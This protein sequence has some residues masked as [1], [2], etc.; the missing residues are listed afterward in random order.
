[1]MDWGLKGDDRT[2]ASHRQ[3]SRAW[4]RRQDQ[5]AEL[6]HSPPLPP[7]L[8]ESWPHPWLALGDGEAGASSGPVLQGLL[9]SAFPLTVFSQH[10]A[11]AL[12]RVSRGQDGAKEQGAELAR[13]Q[14]KPS[15]LWR[16]LPPPPIPASVSSQPLPSWVGESQ[17]RCWAR[18]H[19]PPLSG[20]Q[21]Y[22]GAGGQVKGRWRAVSVS[23][24]CPRWFPWRS[25]TSQCRQGQS[26]P[27]GVCCKQR[28]C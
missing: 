17:A 9:G 14:R 28:R 19:L 24:R 15:E 20:S 4:G 26:R 3:P 16:L 7:T 10:G 18:C 6:Q 25:C 2:Q 12:G 21:G 5:P 8:E 23:P 27:G 22:R 1:M 11:G 13:K